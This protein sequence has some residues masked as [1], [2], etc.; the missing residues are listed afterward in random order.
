MGKRERKNTAKITATEPDFYYTHGYTKY[1]LISECTW[2]T[3]QCNCGYLIELSDS[4]PL[5]IQMS[6]YDLYEKKNV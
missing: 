2:Y 1:T 5:L 4:S 6:T 3:L